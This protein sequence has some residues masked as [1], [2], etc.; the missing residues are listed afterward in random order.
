MSSR[1]VKNDGSID[2]EQVFE[3]P[4][5]GFVSLIQQATTVKGI[6]LCSREIV[7]K[8]FVRDT[9]S[10]KRAAFQHI[11]DHLFAGA[12]DR[13]SDKQDVRSRVLMVMRQ[14]K[15]ERINR[16]ALALEKKQTEQERREAELE[17]DD[18]EDLVAVE[19]GIDPTD[20]E[21]LLI[22][23]FV[24]S[25]RSRFETLT[26]NIDARQA[27]GGSLPYLLST[28]FADRFIEIL[29][30]DFG[31]SLA[32]PY[33][34]LL[35]QIE[36]APIDEREQMLRDVMREP[37]ERAT[38]W[39]AW[40]ILWHEMTN[41]KELPLEPDPPKKKTF[42][43][44]I[45]GDD[46]PD[47]AKPMTPEEW[48]EEVQ[49]IKRENVKVQKLWNRIALPREGIIEPASADKE[50]LLDLFARTPASIETQIKAIDQISTEKD[51]LGRTFDKYATGKSLDLALLVAV[52]RQPKVYLGRRTV[53]KT[54][55]ASSRGAQRE[56]NFPLTD[57]FLGPF[58]P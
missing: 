41:E 55:L 52:Y 35:L 23:V 7:N 48:Q 46:Q 45:M 37:T 11:L 54:M 13:K 21:G 31:P 9:D 5:T 16:A 58:I 22:H 32:R 57:R 38:A 17:P 51:G 1:P 14:V 40:R 25:Y 33:R 6:E 53:L 8:L 26:T 20:A 10:E 43:Q 34:G 36:N 12:T 2:W 19:G 39:E 28:D 49:V 29:R 27:P 42:L 3:H 15:T 50:A 44:K 18:S 30:D 24:D 56:R 47:W 4:Q